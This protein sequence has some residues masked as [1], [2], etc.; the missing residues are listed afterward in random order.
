MVFLC[1]LLTSP[2][3]RPL[4][5]HGPSGKN[6]G[7]I[8]SKRLAAKSTSEVDTVSDVTCI[9]LGRTRRHEVK[10][11]LILI[12]PDFSQSFVVVSHE[13]TEGVGVRGVL[14][15][16]VADVGTGQDLQATSTHPGLRKRKMTR[17]TVFSR[18]IICCKLTILT[19][20]ATK[21]NRFKT[22]SK[23]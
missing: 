20:R 3:F 4:A 1:Y 19:T 10:E 15:E 6:I 21:E 11:V 8:P 12:Q 7:K 14:T 18:K 5:G 9:Q 22:L 2:Y 16:D 23:V 17:K 13:V